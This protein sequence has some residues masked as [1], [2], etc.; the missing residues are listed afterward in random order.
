VADYSAALLPYLHELGDV[1]VDRPGDFNVYHI[2]NN[3]LHREIYARALAN[4]GTVVIH[5]AVLHHFM[6]GTLPEQ[7]YIDEFA[8]NYGEASRGTARELWRDR[9]RSGVDPRY[10]GYP[11]LRRIVE[12]SRCVIVHNSAAARMVRAHASAAHVV[13]IPHLLRPMLPA[14]PKD[15]AELR[16]RMGIP[17][18]ATLAAT[19]GHQRETKRLHVLLRAFHHALARGANLH[20]LVSGAF[21]SASF[22]KA[23]LPLLDH[24]RIVRAGYLAES[25]FAL[26]ACAADVCVNLRYPTAGETSGIAISLMGLGKPVIFTA[27]EELARF[28]E[29]ACLTVESGPGE[30]TAM[31]E[32]LVSLAGNPELGPAIGSRAAAHVRQAHAP[33]SCARAY[34]AAATGER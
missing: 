12:A 24:P 23:V 34:W 11:M 30:E 14:P 29:G 28:P 32:Y 1:V 33:E 2:G 16:R 26:H 19:F 22:E 20:L 13:E 4:P 15:V 21:V 8:F 9:A 31:A 25:D 7:S 18:D 17:A 3:H 10:F 6:L 27:G 5:D